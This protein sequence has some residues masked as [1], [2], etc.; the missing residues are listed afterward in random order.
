MN[1]FLNQINQCHE[2]SRTAGKK[3][4]HFFKFEDSRCTCVF[5]GK[6]IHLNSF[7]SIENSISNPDHQLAVVG[8]RS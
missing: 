5:C 4:S 2:A 6:Q 1:Q 8:Q 7:N 3:V